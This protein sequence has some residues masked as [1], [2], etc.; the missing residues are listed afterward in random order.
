M[1][2]YFLHS[3]FVILCRFSTGVGSLGAQVAVRTVKG[4]NL[5]ICNVVPLL[6]L[7]LVNFAVVHDWLSAEGT[8]AFPGGSCRKTIHISGKRWDH[9]TLI[10][11]QTAKAGLCLPVSQSRRTDFERIS[12]Q[13]KTCSSV[14]GLFLWDASGIQSQKISLLR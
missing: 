7:G 5:Y 11:C 10:I 1:L 13:R 4:K 6:Y 8:A 3:L 2:P 12:Y 9:P 14:A